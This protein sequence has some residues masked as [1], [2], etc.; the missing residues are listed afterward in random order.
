V[1]NVFGEENEV[2]VKKNLGWFLEN[3]ETV[4]MEKRWKPRGGEEQ[5]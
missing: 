3:L 5:Q 4:E 2:G 1:G